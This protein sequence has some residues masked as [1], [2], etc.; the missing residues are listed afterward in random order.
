MPKDFQLEVSDDIAGPWRVIKA[1]V[2][3]ATCPEEHVGYA[4]GLQLTAV[5]LDPTTGTFQQ[6]FAGFH[7]TSRVRH[8]VLSRV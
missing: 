7:A 2:G 1:F 4:L 5:Q 3:P 8:L 6:H